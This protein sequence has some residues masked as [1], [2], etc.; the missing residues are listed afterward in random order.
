MNSTTSAPSHWPTL[1]LICT[2]PSLLNTGP[3]TDELGLR[4]GGETR[5]RSS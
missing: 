1:A 4:E 5:E 2:S 3:P